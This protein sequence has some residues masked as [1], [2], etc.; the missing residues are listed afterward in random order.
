MGK[1]AYSKS[2]P[3]LN[4]IEEDMRTGARPGGILGKPQKLV[5][6]GI[7][8]NGESGLEPVQLSRV[9]RQV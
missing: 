9:L 2:L 1:L 5:E 4:I 7:I 8:R 6:E 3:H